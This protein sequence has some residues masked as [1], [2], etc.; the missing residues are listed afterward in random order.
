M[1]NIA[2]LLIII[3]IASITL[4]GSQQDKGSKVKEE[5]KEDIFV[6]T[7]T[8]TFTPT[9]TIKPRPKPTFTPTSTPTLEPTQAPQVQTLPQINPNLDPLC[10]NYASLK[11][12]ETK[13][14]LEKETWERFGEIPPPLAIQ[15]DISIQQLYYQL[16]NACLKG[17][18]K[19]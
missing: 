16:Y 3:G 13:Q 17:E 11:S 12:M 5:I 4:Y 7:P 10:R 14:K 8:P 1:R 9:P 19:P 2:F 6:V 18:I 15:L